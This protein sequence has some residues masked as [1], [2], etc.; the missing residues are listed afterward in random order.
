MSPLRASLV[1]V[2]M[3]NVGFVQI[4]EAASGR[5]LWP[6]YA[7]ALAS[8]LLAPLAERRTYRGLW[9]VAVLAIFGM[10]VQHAAQSG[11]R[12]LL[13]DGLVLAAFCQVHLLNTLHA[14]QRPD[15][16]FLNSFLIALVTSFFCQD[17]VFCGV[18]A[19]Y[20]FVLLACQPC[21]SKR[22]HV[23]PRRYGVRAPRWPRGTLICRTTRSE[24]TVLSLIH[25]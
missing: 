5:W 25:I 20:T 22:A 23:A 15:L 19:L 7:L 14:R 13:E 24:T 17:L 21:S 4:T 16:L 9:N 6:M 2:V 1:A 18:F 8:P 10:L 12:H 3:L 11:I